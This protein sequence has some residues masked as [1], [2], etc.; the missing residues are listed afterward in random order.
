MKESLKKAIINAIGTNG[1]VNAKNLAEELNVTEQTVYRGIRVLLDSGD[2]EKT[3][4][5]AYKLKQSQ[6]KFSYA[7]TASLDE[8]SVWMQDIA[9]NLPPLT[10]NAKKALAYI[11]TE[12]MNNAIEHS[13]ANI[14]QVFMIANL[15]S[16]TIY[17]LD[18]GIGIFE[19]ISKALSLPEKKYAVLELAKGKFTTDPSSHTG[20][21]IFFSS[22][23]ADF[24]AIHS[25]KI[26][27][28]GTQNLQQP[29]LIE[30]EP[31]A[32][33]T[34]ITFEVLNEHNDSI[35]SVFEK[36][37]NQ[38]EDYGFSKTMIP[39]KL[40]AYGEQECLFMSRSQ[41]RRLL[42]RLDKFENIEL[43]FSE[44]DEIGQG[45]ADEVFRVFANEHPNVVIKVVNAC[46]NVMKM[47]RHVK[48]GN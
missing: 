45:F 18:D 21:G 29:V 26:A 43:D 28:I 46:E 47:I 19:K 12:M 7:K 34:L 27:F 24:F 3:Q 25:Q 17:I 30:R 8:D 42:A 15:Y 31:I 5:G 2:I 11:F 39:V 14:V 48:N 41:A 9:P 38:P 36:Y 44:I 40:V 35:T 22:K 37:T 10:V 23:I 1:A 33:G 16:T 6:Y 20:E 13:E 4:R 32:N